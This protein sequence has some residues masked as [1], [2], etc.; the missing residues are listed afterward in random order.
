M[1]SRAPGS[2]LIKSDHFVIKIQLRNG[3]QTSR[4]DFDKFDDVLIKMLHFL[5]QNQLRNGIQRS[6]LDFDEK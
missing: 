6:R 4:L 5:I 2:I 1:A 3:I